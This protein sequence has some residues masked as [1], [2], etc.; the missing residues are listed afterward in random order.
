MAVTKSTAKSRKVT[1]SGTPEICKDCVLAKAKKASVPKEKVDLS[2]VPGE[3]L[4]INI[5][6]PSERSIGGN[7]H[8][9]LV[10]DD[11]SDFP[12]SFFL[13]HKD[14]LKTKLVPLIKSLKLQGTNAKI[15][16][17]DNAGENIAFERAAEQEGLN[18]KFEYT[19]PD[20]PQQNGRV[21]RKF[22]TLYGR[23]QAMLFSAEQE[24]GIKNIKKLWCEAAET[25][26]Q[27]DGIFGERWRDF[28]LFSEI[29]WEGI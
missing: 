19:A 29:L 25:A 8:W 2:K 7:R 15:I 14:M 17:C 11:Y 23:V 18:L 3:R 13:S 26:T 21:E 10:L 12:M 24:M 22:Q 20:M 6:S 16:R 27:Y 5:S 1:I 28:E 4:F 9:L